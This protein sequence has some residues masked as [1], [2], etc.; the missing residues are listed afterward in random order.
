MPFP[1]AGAPDIIT[2]KGSWRLLSSAEIR[3]IGDRLEVLFVCKREVLRERGDRDKALYEK[4][5]AIE[6]EDD[7][8]L[9]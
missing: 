9:G 8:I 2:F 6:E 3:K 7:A 4:Q 5:K 1:D